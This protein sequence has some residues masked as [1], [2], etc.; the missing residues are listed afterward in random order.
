[1]GLSSLLVLASDRRSVLLPQG[2]CDAPPGTLPLH[3]Q[4][5]ADCLRQ[6]VVASRR[7]CH[8]ELSLYCSPC[9]M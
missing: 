4:A 5:R 9:W 6:L 2:R 7:Q 1:M 8:E 3:T